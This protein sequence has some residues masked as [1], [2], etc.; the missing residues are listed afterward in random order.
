MKRRAN[1]RAMSLRG[2]AAFVSAC[3]VVLSSAVMAASGAAQEEEFTW[4]DDAS[5]FVTPE[6]DAQIAAEDQR[7]A[8]EEATRNTPE[9]IADRQQ[10]RTAYA[11]LSDAAA[12]AV[13]RELFPEL[14]LHRTWT[15]FEAPQG[16]EIDRYFGRNT[17]LVTET[18][19]Q[20][21][22]V[23]DPM[24]EDPE[25]GQM[26][27]SVLPLRAED[28]SGQLRPLDPH[29]DD[30]GAYFEPAN[31][32][33]DVEIPEDLSDG[34]TLDEADVTVTPQ[35]AAQADD[36]ARVGPDK[37]FYANIAADTDFFATPLPTGAEAFWLLRSQDSPTSLGLNL[38]LPA[39]ADVEEQAGGAMIVDGDDPL[40]GI[41]PPSAYDADGRQVPVELSV[42]DGDVQVTVDHR[43]G[44]IAYPVVVDPSYTYYPPET[45]WYRWDSATPGGYLDEISGYGQA[46]GWGSNAPSRFMN[47]YYYGI[48]NSNVWNQNFAI[49]DYSQ[50]VWQAP[51]N[52]SIE[53]AEFYN[54]YHNHAA[55]ENFCTTFGIWSWSAFN[56]E[57]TTYEL[58]ENGGITETGNGPET[59]CNPYNH[60][61]DFLTV[62]SNPY[63]D[64]SGGDPEGTLNN[65][66]VFQ[67]FSNQSGYVAGQASDWIRGAFFY[68]YDDADPVM[69][70]GGRSSSGWTDDGGQSYTLTTPAHATDQGVGVKYFNLS[71]PN[72]QGQ[73]SLLDQAMHGCSGDRA[74]RCPKD[75][76]STDARMNHQ[77]SYT[78]PEGANTVQLSA[79]DYTWRTSSPVSWTQKIDRTPPDLQLSGSLAAQDSKILDQ[80]TYDLSA[81]ANDGSSASPST[82]RSGVS[83][84]EVKLDGV[85]KVLVTP[86]CS[87]GDCP[88][89][90]NASW[91]L[92]AAQLQPGTHTVEIKA[93]D[94]LN[95]QRIK[96]LTLLVAPDTTIT[97]GP[98]GATNNND[99]SFAFAGIPPSAVIRFECR[100][101]GGQYSTCTSPKSYTD[102]ADGSHTFSVRAVGSVGADPSPA[103]RT[104]FV[105]TA[106]PGLTATGWGVDQAPLGSNPNPLVGAQPRVNAT[107]TDAGSGVSDLSILIDGQVLDSA[108]DQCTTPGCSVEGPLGP[109]LSALPAGSHSYSVRALDPAGNATTISGTMR[110]D[111]AFPALNVSGPLFDSQ[112]QPLATASAVANIQATDSVAGDSGVKRVE[113][114]VNGNAASTQN[115]TCAPTCPGSV[116]ASYTYNKA[117]WGPGSNNVLIVATDA[118]GNRRETAMDV[119]VQPPA[120]AALCPQAPQ[121]GQPGGTILTPTQA[122]AAAIPGAVAPSVSS[123]DSEFDTDL[124]PS[125]DQPSGTPQPPLEAVGSVIDSNL[126]AAPAGGFVVD[127]VACLVPSAS[128]TAETAAT[129]ANG[130]SA[131]YANSADSTD[132]IVRPTAAGVTVIESVRNSSA[133]SSF[134]WKVG[135]QSGYAL[136]QAGDVVAVIDPSRNVQGVNVPARPN[137]AEDP[138]KIGDAATQMAEQRYQVA[139]A[140]QKTGKFVAAVITRPYSVSTNGSS[141]VAVVT[142]TGGNTVTVSPKQADP[143]RKAY[144]LPVVN[145]PAKSSVPNPLPAFYMNVRSAEDLKEKA[146]QMACTATGQMHSGRRRVLL[147]DFGAAS[148]DE[149]KFGVKLRSEHFFTNKQVYHAML[150]AS[151]KTDECLDSGTPFLTFGVSNN[152]PEG[153]SDSLIRDSADS[154]AGWAEKVFQYQQEKYPNVMGT[155]VASDIE[156]TWQQQQ[157]GYERTRLHVER[158]KAKFS[159]VFI[160]Y[161][162]AK[163]CP[164]KPENGGCDFGWTLDNYAHLS[165]SSGV[166]TVFPEIYT[167]MAARQWANIRDHAGN[168]A[169]FGG[170]TGSPPN[171]DD[172]TL[173]ARESWEKL[174][175]QVPGRVQRDLVNIHDACRNTPDHLC[176]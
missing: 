71:G 10:S 170:V 126:G 53:H 160:N 85:S 2:A 56:W 89:S 7:A 55:G 16:L 176:P 87:S 17:A 32:V 112:G 165:F 119:D 111:P 61:S 50:W 140:E 113:V 146:R 65:A 117:D 106:G 92:D 125:L 110:L 148:V 143:Q 76:T 105:D 36:A 99:P 82:Q 135:L 68:M 173:T 73:W 72:A 129:L 41:E 118:A 172:I 69:V 136:Q 156:A 25:A 9:A 78:L 18:G 52:T 29:L 86:T 127:K 139:L 134:S 157:A 38:E 96:T 168:G 11:G 90:A 14:F 49:W 115:Q 169:V 149:G 97:S 6:V 57:P 174:A 167:P 84:L 70:S 28:D 58:H 21:P 94:Q 27:Q 62:G 8:V 81:T 121:P 93:L 77:I 51:A 101:D 122:Q 141:D 23:G 159:G 130:D 107:A 175:D 161:G 103:T 150:S 63:Q 166:S 152:F 133:P 144:V 60:S 20:Q 4:P 12:E 47:A 104:F 102:L 162:N 42:V 142:T 40:A 137:G 80:Q 19:E 147:Y 158:I 138:T 44:D 163:G 171:G 120:P 128:T 151:D 48:W 37:V 153:W 79:S 35:G 83:S 95:H 31:A 13:A 164:P 75:L 131:I 74:D 98:S 116:N 145:N 15:P 54:T 67:L 45:D 88:S 34:L 132:T 46:W 108:G 154:I 66:V 109:D 155:A 43:G 64:F 124:D 33:A 100:L 24:P 26:L 123:F 1:N 30:E 39:G 91:T 5:A 3:A 59:R 114:K 22:E